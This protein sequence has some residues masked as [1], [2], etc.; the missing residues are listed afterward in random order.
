[1]GKSA[2][3]PSFHVSLPSKI[4]LVRYGNYYYHCTKHTNKVG[5]KTLF[6][7]Y[8]QEKKHFSLS[9]EELVP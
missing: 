9:S 3:S 6:T 7:D 1:M 5:Q 8:F 2:S 4:E